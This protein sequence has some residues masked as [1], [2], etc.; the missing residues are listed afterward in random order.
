MKKYTV[1]ILV[2]FGSMMLAQS[3]MANNCQDM[4]KQFIKKSDSKPVKPV[5]TKK[6]ITKPAVVKEEVKPIVKETVKPVK[7]VKPEAPKVKYEYV[8]VKAKL[9]SRLEYGDISKKDYSLFLSVT[10]EFEKKNKAPLMG[11][12]MNKCFDEFSSEAAESMVKLVNST[13]GA[14][15]SSETFDRLV[16]GSQ[17]IFGDSKAAAKTKICALSQGNNCK[18][19][20]EAIARHCK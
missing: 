6:E 7:A 16:K 13:K 9:D 1:A 15:N 12:G 18:L 11:E 10:D 14:K 19:F 3:A 17:D 20:S 8:N 5:V 4:M 2:T